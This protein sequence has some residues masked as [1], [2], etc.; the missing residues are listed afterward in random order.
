MAQSGFRVAVSVDLVLLTLDEDALSVALLPRSTHPGPDN[1]FPGELALPGGTIDRKADADLDA[2]VR[3]V[4]TAK[5]GLVPGYFEQLQTFGDH[6]R[7]PRE[8]TL[9]VAYFALVKRSDIPADNPLRLAKVD[10]I[11]RLP[12]DHNRIL[13]CAVERV[14]SKSTYS[15]LPLVFLPPEFTLTEMRAVYEQVW[16][17]SVD[18]VRFQRDVEAMDVLEGLNTFSQTGGRPARLFRKRRSIKGV[19]TVGTSLGRR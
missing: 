8:W 16:G 7:D 15:T 10:T 2:T 1:A 17:E 18:R 6:L 12:F 9:S 11:G 19:A 3:R 4:M 13:A 14:R 5:A